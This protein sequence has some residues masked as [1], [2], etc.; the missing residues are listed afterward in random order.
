VYAV[1][2]QRVRI[3]MSALNWALGG[4]GARPTFVARASRSNA[5]GTCGNFYV[6]AVRQQRVSILM[7]AINRAWDS[8][9]MRAAP[10]T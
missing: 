10:H 3:L 1:M 7:S 4:A 5:L 9:G 6:A 2:M 8:G